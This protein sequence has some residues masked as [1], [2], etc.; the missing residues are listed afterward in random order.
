LHALHREANAFAAETS[1]RGAIVGRIGGFERPLELRRRIAG[2]YDAI[3]P[4]TR[5]FPFRQPFD[6]GLRRPF[7]PNVGR[8][9]L[10]R[11]ERTLALLLA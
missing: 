7:E 4:K 2:Q 6:A 11:S 5:R 3:D 9:F 8:G 1:A 10:L